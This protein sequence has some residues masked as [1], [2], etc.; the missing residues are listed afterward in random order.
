MNTRLA[1]IA[2]A[3]TLLAGTAQA[4]ILFDNGPIVDGANISILPT[5]SNILGF[6]SNGSFRL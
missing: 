5:G 3:A 2:V 4:A 1:A 6:T